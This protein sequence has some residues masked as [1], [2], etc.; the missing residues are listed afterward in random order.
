MDSNAVL[1]RVLMRHRGKVNK[2]NTI[3]GLKP[4]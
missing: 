3:I 4:L 1:G 2:S